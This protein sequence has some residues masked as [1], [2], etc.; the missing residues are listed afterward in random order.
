[1]DQRVFTRRSSAVALGTGVLVAVALG[2]FGAPW[3]LAV[4]TGLPAGATV[5]GLS[6]G[7]RNRLF[8]VRSR[9]W[10]PAPWIGAFVVGLTVVLVPAANL[11][12]F[13][14]LNLAT[15]AALE[16]LFGLTGFAALMFGYITRMLEELAA[17]EDTSD[18]SVGSATPTDQHPAS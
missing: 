8:R 15:E 17:A 18:A 2:Q 14:E 3:A 1:M 9:P 4:F 11:S 6:F 16:L 13:L 7:A 12:P 5:L 10:A